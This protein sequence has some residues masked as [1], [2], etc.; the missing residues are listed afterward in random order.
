MLLAAGAG[1]AAWA[2]GYAMSMPV[3]IIPAFLYWRGRVVYRRATAAADM[4]H[5]SAQPERR[6][7]IWRVIRVLSI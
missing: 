1:D 2:A 7:F 5:L 4:M 6:A 3:A